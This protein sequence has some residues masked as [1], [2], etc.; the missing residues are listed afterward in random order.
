MYV[1]ALLSQFKKKPKK[2]RERKENNYYHVYQQR[3]KILP[4]D[5]ITRKNRYKKETF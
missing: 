1:C 4:L 5:K 2:N 3:K